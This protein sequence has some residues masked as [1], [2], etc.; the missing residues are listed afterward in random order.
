MPSHNPGTDNQK[1]DKGRHRPGHQG[2]PD[3]QQSQ[4]SSKRPSKGKNDNPGEFAPDP[5]R[6][7]KPGQKCGQS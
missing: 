3:D 6:A 5:D 4:D 7:R 1:D 2:S